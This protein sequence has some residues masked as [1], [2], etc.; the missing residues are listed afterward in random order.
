[1]QSDGIGVYRSHVGAADE[2]FKFVKKLPWTPSSG[3][4]YFNDN[5]LIDSQLGDVIPE[6]H[7]P[8]PDGVNYLRA[9][10]DVLH[11]WGDPAHK[12]RMYWSTIGTGEYFASYDFPFMTPDDET[13]GG[14]VDMGDEG[15]VIT[16]VLPDFWSYNESGARGSLLLV[17]TKTRSFYWSGMTWLDH[18]RDDGWIEGAVSALSGVARAGYMGWVGRNGPSIK[19]AGSSSSI[20]VWQLLF[21]ELRYPFWDVV[22]KG[23]GTV[24]Y[25]ELCSGAIWRGWYVFTWAENPSIIPNRMA[26]VHIKSGTVCEIGNPDADQVVAASSVMVWDGPGDNGELFYASAQTGYI[27]QLF[28]DQGG[29]SYWSTTDPV[30]TSVKHRTGL[31]LRSNEVKNIYNE[32]HVGTLMLVFDRPKVDQQINVRIYA[33]GDNSDP[34]WQTSAPLTIS[35]AGPGDRV[36]LP[37]DD[38]SADG[39]AFQVEWSGNFTVPVVLEG[40]LMMDDTYGRL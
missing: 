12:N 9:V 10:N 2:R 40:I 35:S 6:D 3:T 30:G 24:D 32:R 31:L 22:T 26:M 1:M 21:P 33:D 37:V 25:F 29:Y 7:D 34:V 11:A 20:P 28:A 39:R 16:S 17:Q 23:N 36:Y 14:R 4:I 15:E 38:I 13:F 27:Y 8:P 18:R 5:E 19:A